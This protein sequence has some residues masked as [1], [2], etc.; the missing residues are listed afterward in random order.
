MISKPIII[1]ACRWL[2]LALLR[3]ES[4][5]R[6]RCEFLRELHIF[7]KKKKKKVQLDK[8]LLMS[9]GGERKTGE[10]LDL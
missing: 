9:S 1:S 7:R 6:V 4:A 3:S 10:S 5:N 8:V 2:L